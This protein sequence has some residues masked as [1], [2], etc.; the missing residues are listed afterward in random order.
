MKLRDSALEQNPKLCISSSVSEQDS[1]LTYRLSHGI[2]FQRGIPGL[3]RVLSL[4]IL[5]WS[6]MPKASV[7]IC[8]ENSA[9]KHLSAELKKDKKMYEMIEGRNIDE[10]IRN[11]Q[12]GKSTGVAG[13]LK[14]PLFGSYSGYPPFCMAFVNSNHYVVLHFKKVNGSIPAPPIDGWWLRKKQIQGLPGSPIHRWSYQL[15]FI[16]HY[17][18]SKLDT[19]RFVRSKGDEFENKNGLEGRMDGLD[20]HPTESPP[21]AQ[22]LASEDSKQ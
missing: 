11:T 5:L 10:D 21:G 16:N 7:S 4:G 20:L 17:E 22:H 14:M 13:W 6:R 12:A 15:P 3:A 9:E 8:F 1:R 2:L 19:W 18:T